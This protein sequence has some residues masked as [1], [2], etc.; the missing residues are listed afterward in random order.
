MDYMNCHNSFLGH[1]QIH[2]PF[3]L[4]K[5]RKKKE[6]KEERTPKQCRFERHCSPSSLRM[7]RQGRRRFFF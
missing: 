7:Q 3:L 6:K 2:F 5:K 1:F 4:K